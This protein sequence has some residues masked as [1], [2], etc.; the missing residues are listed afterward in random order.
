MKPEFLYT[1]RML[2]LN[3]LQ[4]GDMGRLRELM[5]EYKF[6]MSWED[7]LHFSRNGGKIGVD[8]AYNSII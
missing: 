7:E 4:L 5:I 1:L 3:I 6:V 2:T 8:Q